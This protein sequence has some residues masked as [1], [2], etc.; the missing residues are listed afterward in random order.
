MPPPP[1][2]RVFER[3]SRL[4]VCFAYFW[5]KSQHPSLQKSPAPCR[6]SWNCLVTDPLPWLSRLSAA[7]LHLHGTA[8]S[9]VPN[10]SMSRLQLSHIIVIANNGD[11]L[12]YEVHFVVGNHVF[13][14]SQS[15]FFLLPCGFNICTAHDHFEDL[16]S[17]RSPCPFIIFLVSPV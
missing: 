3:Y 1:E 11:K 14:N 12:P 7:H 9:F 16:W 4:H 6:E 13:S 5:E 10:I 8:N 15:F 2:L 17:H